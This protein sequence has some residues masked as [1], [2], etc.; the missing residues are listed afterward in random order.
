MFQDEPGHSSMGEIDICGYLRG[1][2][3]YCLKEFTEFEL[4]I[5]KQLKLD[6]RML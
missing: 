5:I 3:V 1:E 2:N 6:L 4:K